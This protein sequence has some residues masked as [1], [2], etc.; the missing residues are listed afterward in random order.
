MRVCAHADN[1]VAPWCDPMRPGLGAA[2]GNNSYPCL[3]AGL[4]FTQIIH[5]S[6]THNLESVGKTWHLLPIPSI[7]FLAFPWTWMVHKIKTYHLV[8]SGR[9]RSVG[10]APRL[11]TLTLAH[12][13]LEWCTKLNMILGCGLSWFGVYSNYPI[14]FNSYNCH[15]TFTWA[16]IMYKIKTYHLV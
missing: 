7:A 16:W 8:W 4:V 14:S 2:R 11:L 10:T 5:I 12:L 1:D 9:G 15:L 13:E 3:L 6:K